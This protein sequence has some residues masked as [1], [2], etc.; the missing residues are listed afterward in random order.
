[1]TS[2]L[3]SSRAVAAE[4]PR[5]RSDQITLDHSYSCFTANADAW[6]DRSA[7]GPGMLSDLKMDAASCQERGDVKLARL[8]VREKRCP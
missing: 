1:M 6:I 5:E 3:S 2:G 8:L 7:G 4:I